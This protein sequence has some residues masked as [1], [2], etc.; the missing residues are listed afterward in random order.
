KFGTDGWRG[1]IAEDFTFDNVRLCAQAVATYLGKQQPGR[2]SLAIGY[3]TRFAS[4]DFAAACAEVLAAHGV[5]AFL[6]PQPTPTPVTVFGLLEKKAGAGIIITASHNPYRYNGFKLREHDG[7]ALSP[8]VASHLESLAATALSHPTPPLPL[9]QALSQGLVQYYEPRPAYMARLASL[10]DIDRLRHAP[11]KVVVDPMYGAGR[12]YLAELL[13]K[14]R[15][16]LSHIHH[17][18]NPAFPGLTPEPIAPNLAPLGAAVRRRHAHIGLATDGDADRV[19][20]VDERGRPLS[21]PEAFA[22]LA[23]YFL[24]FRGQ[25]GPIIR[26]LPSTA[27]LDR[28]ADR[29]GVPV[30]RTPVGFKHIAPLML[31]Q[32]ALLAGEESGGYGFRGHVPERDGVM[33]SLC[34]ADMLLLT[35]KPL[36]AL[37]EYLYQKVGRHYYRRDDIHFPPARR[38]EMQQ[39]LEAARPTALDGVTVASRDTRDGF[40]FL[41]ADGSWLLIRFS[42]TEPLM[43]VYVESTVPERVEGLL[44]AGKQLAGV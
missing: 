1:I 3:D 40:Y 8:Q 12:G 30:T 14:G 25:R 18:R 27:M 37:V 32:D 13:G 16:E 15:I 20:V 5:P 10:V 26:S 2:L 42:G 33:A 38:E 35:G 43:R 24:E 23:L 29:F 28:L 4:E 31:T 41:M 19:G 22:L 9:S 21:A 6:C 44:A 36:S 7:T 11:L 39:R 17:Q 34:F